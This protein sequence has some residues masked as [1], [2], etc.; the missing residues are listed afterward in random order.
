MRHVLNR[1][2]L[3]R[4]LGAGSGVGADA[5]P[6]GPDVAERMG[7][8]LTV[9]D[10]ITLRTG[11]ARAEAAVCRAAPAASVSLEQALAQLR[12]NVGQSIAG[13]STSIL[14]PTRRAHVPW[15]AAPPEPP[16]LDPATEFTLLHQR[17]SEQQRRMELAVSAL[18]VH[19]RAVLAATSPGLAKLAALDELMG[20]VLDARAQNLYA[21]VPAFLKARFEQRR[22]ASA[23]SKA[24]AGPEADPV[25]SADPA[26][27]SWL[28][29]LCAEFQ[30]ALRAELDLR[31]QPIVGMVA[32]QREAEA[33]ASHSPDAPA[34][35]V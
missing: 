6:N 1:S 33:S 19:A 25:D 21:T 27:R 16:P 2:P 7:A 22:K 15:G 24:A 13:L 3:Q 12:A 32:A 35:R 34:L 5:D 28:N 18:R 20:Q 8:W 10:A 30:Q 9:A 23:E 11:L 4:L 29:A 26:D 14:P 17:Y 31:L